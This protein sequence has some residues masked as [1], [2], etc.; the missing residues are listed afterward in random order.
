[1]M[2][3][4]RRPLVVGVSEFLSVVF[5]SPHSA[6]EDLLIVCWL[7]VSVLYLRPLSAMLLLELAMKN[8]M[9]EVGE[10]QM[11]WQVL[12]KWLMLTELKLEVAFELWMRLCAL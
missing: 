4:K 2:V 11:M 7:L 6:L 1:M 3:L 10:S 12:Q 8:E 9:I 5:S